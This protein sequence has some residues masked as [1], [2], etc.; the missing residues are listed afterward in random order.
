MSTRLK[1]DFFEQNTVKVA[2]SLLGKFLI[3]KVKNNTI[4]AKIVE[5]EAYHGLSDKASHASKNRTSRNEIMF[6]DAGVAYIYFVYGMHYMFNIVCGRTQFPA[7][8]LIRAVE[9]EGVDKNK[10]NG[11]AK[12]CKFLKIDKSLNKENLIT[13]NSL[14]VEARG[15]NPLSKDIVKTERVGVEYSG[16]SAN[17]LWRF[18]INSSKFISR[19]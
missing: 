9:I 13:S 12:L 4:V 14:W 11:P 6:G 3:R 17:L 16:D 18:Y 10:T 2:K 1:K 8:V 19:K 7:A 5:V 15:K